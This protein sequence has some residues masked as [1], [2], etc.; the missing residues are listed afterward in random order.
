MQICEYLGKKTKYQIIVCDPLVNAGVYNQLQRFE[1][2]NVKNLKNKYFIKKFKAI[3]VMTDH[4]IFDYNLLH[5]N[6]KILIDCTN[7]YSNKKFKKV[8]KI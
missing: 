1:F 8:I 7:I 4:D 5:K 3:I 2:E 6:S